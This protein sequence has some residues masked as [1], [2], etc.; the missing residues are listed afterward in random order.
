MPGPSSSTVTTPPCSATVTV[1][2]GG[3]HLAA[4]SSRLVR[5]RSRAGASPSTYHGSAATSND[6]D[7]RAAADP[8]HRL[9]EDLVQ[10]D[11]ADHRRR[12]LVAG[13]L[14]QVADQGGELLEL[15]AYVG[16]QLGARLVGERAR[17]PG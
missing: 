16:Q 1:P 13:Q 2:A 10:L 14:D 6:S 15:G 17:R 8:G 5:A 9:V 4:L 7:G 3:L 11:G 12:G